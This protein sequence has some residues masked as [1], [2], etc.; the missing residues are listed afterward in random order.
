[1]LFITVIFTFT[2]LFSQQFSNLDFVE[3]DGFNEVKIIYY[4]YQDKSSNPNPIR[5]L[6]PIDSLDIYK[7]DEHIFIEKKPEK[8]GESKLCKKEIKK[9]FKKLKVNNSAKYIL[10]SDY[11]IYLEFY[12]D[13]K[14]IQ[15]ILANTF[16]NNL[17]I[18]KEGCKPIQMEGYEKY[19]CKYLGQMTPEFKNYLKKLLKKKKII[20]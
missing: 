13:D 1:M 16:S 12:R 18:S 11:N 10:D 2:N 9:L 17:V 8:L 20:D 7:G 4:R 6:V 14:L 15:E 3:K 19:P 5:K